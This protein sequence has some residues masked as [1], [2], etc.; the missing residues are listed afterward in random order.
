MLFAPRAY[1]ANPL[2]FAS[3]LRFDL[4]CLAA[5]IARH[6]R[7]NLAPETLSRARPRRTERV[8]TKRGRKTGASSSRSDIAQSKAFA[9][10]HKGPGENALVGRAPGEQSGENSAGELE[11][12][13]GLTTNGARA[14]AF[15]RRRP[16]SSQRYTLV[17]RRSSLP[18]SVDQPVRPSWL[19]K[20]KF[21]RTDAVA[22]PTRSHP[23]VLGSKED[24]LTSLTSPDPSKQ[25]RDTRIVERP[26]PGLESSWDT[27]VAR[28]TDSACVVCFSSTPRRHWRAYVGSKRRA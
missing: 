15:S 8:F 2:T 23:I 25:K 20:L 9:C 19:R 11:R 5:F 12:N 13:A 18:L 24:G 7:R 26:E 21:G 10:A 1:R 27:L 3:H 4:V 14:R 6:R 17:E 28:R 22:Y 16:L